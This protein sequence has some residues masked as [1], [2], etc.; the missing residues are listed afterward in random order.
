[1]NGFEYFSF[2][3]LQNPEVSHI[4]GNDCKWKVPI[5]N[6]NIGTSAYIRII[7]FIA[8]VIWICLMVLCQKIKQK[9]SIKTQ[10]NN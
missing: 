4:S 1:M 3:Q 9:Q 7:T 8:N 2:K 10:L 5:L 6:E